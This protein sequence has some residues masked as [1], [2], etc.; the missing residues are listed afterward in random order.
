MTLN[1][2]SDVDIDHVVPLAEAWRSGADSWTTDRRR[3][4]ANDLGGPQL[5]ASA[6]TAGVVDE[7]AL[8]IAP[9]LVGG[10]SRLLAGR[11]PAVV[12]PE[13]RQVLEEDGVLFTRY[14]L[15]A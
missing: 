8:T 15:A 3:A 1:S 12:R 2:A 5:L 14:R 13:L 6:L 4:F 9:A 7:L 10:E 11:L